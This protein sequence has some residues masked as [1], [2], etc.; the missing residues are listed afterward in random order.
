MV[1]DDA[2]ISSVDLKVVEE[3]ARVLYRLTGAIRWLCFMF[4]PAAVIKDGF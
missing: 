4:F 1:I 3:D 2:L